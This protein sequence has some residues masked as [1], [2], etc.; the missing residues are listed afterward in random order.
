MAA[1]A[2]GKRKTKGKTLDLNTFLGEDHDAPSGFAVVNTRRIDWADLMDNEDIDDRYTLDFKKD[3]G[4]VVLPTAPKA[5]RGPDVD[6]GRVPEG[7]PYTAFLGNL[8][9]DVTE[10]DISFFFRQLQVKN[11]RLPRENGEKGRIR[12]FGYAEFNNRQDLIQA[13]A[14]NNE[15]L[16]NRAIKVSLAGEH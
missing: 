6:L 4:R 8:P 5:A 3:E 7:P 12:G 11:V 14:L 2:K 9:Y 16:K 1:N 13:L 10:D 15:S